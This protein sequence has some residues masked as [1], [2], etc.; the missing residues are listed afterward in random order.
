MKAVCVHEFGGPEVLTY[1]EMPTPSPAEG[2]VLVRVHAAGV[3]PPDWYRRG[4]DATIP[5]PMRPAPPPLPLLLGSDISGTVVALG[6]GVTEWQEGDEV[7]GLVRFP[8]VDDPGPGYAEDATAPA[9][10]LARK[11]STVDHVQA[12]AVPMAGLTAYQFLFDHIGLAW[13]SKVLVIG[14]AGGVGHFAVQ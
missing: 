13:D 5:A 7:F 4:G 6:A 12:A 8:S 3:N 1:E 14:A 9:N 10:H 11:P 2:E